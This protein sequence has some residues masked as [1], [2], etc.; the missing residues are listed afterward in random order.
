M[1]ILGVVT[2]PYNFTQ[3]VGAK[4]RPWYNLTVR[5]QLT[6]LMPIPWGSHFAVQFYAE[7]WSEDKTMTMVQFDCWGTA[8][9][10]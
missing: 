8:D 6:N 7:C 2:S 9:K 5:V 4:I 10:S 3:N 1:P